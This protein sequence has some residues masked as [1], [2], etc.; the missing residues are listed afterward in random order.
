MKKSI[1]A[2][3]SLLL[4]IGAFFSAAVFAEEHAYTA[5]EHTSAAL[6]QGKAGKAPELVQH[7]QQA[8]EHAKKAEEVALGHSKTQMQSAIKALEKT[9]SQGNSGDAKSASVSAEE[10]LGFLQAGNK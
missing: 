1:L 7:A 4:L 8:L 5:I 3:T 9:I 6:A 2:F 10:A